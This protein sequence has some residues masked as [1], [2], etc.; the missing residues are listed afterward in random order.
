MWPGR[1]TP[2]RRASGLGFG[3]ARCCAP[4]DMTI[5][6]A[7]SEGFSP[8]ALQQLRNRADVIEGDL[9]RDELLAAV[10]SV[11]VLWVRLRNHIDEAI[12]NAA[13]RLRV[14]VT[15]TTGLNHIDLEA[16]H[17]RG[18]HVISLKGEVELLRTVRATAELTLGLMLSLVRRL[19][20][21]AAHVHGGRLGPL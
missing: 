15:N 6:I 16:A 11:D 5:L 21:A 18:I 3:P 8:A 12:L 9:G 7:E 13:Q 19:P 4:S 2:Y 20:A 17:R 10:A 14:I 1:T